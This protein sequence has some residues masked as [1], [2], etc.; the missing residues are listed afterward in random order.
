MTLT[1]RCRVLS[2]CGWGERHWIGLREAGTGEEDLG[3]IWD[4]CRR[5]MEGGRDGQGEMERAE[6]GWREKGDWDWVRNV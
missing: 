6:T 3:V 5:V 1:G 4:S 2:L